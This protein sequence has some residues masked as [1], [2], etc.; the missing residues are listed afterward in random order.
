[1]RIDTF[2]GLNNKD[3]PY[4]VGLSGLVAAD[5]V[6]ISAKNK[7]SRRAG[8]EKVY[9]GQIEA[10]WGD[11][12]T[13]L[14]I[15]DGTLKSLR[16]DNTAETVASL[17]ANARHLHACRAYDNRL[18]WTTPTDAGVIRDGQNRPFGVLKP[19][20]VAAVEGIG[21][22]PAAAYMVGLTYV[23]SFL[24]EGPL[25][26]TSVKAFGSVEVTIPHGVLEL[27]AA[28]IEH[29]RLYLSSPDGEVMYLANE[30]D[31][32]DSNTISYDGD[33]TDLGVPADAANLD[34]LPTG[35]F[36]A[37]YAGRLWSGFGYDG[38]GF[39]AYTSPYAELTNAL[40]DFF[41][42]PE[43]VTGLGG[44]D[45]GRF[46]GLY[47]GTERAVYFLSGSDPGRMESR[48][49][50]DHGV[51]RGTMKKVD[52]RVV[53]KGVD[54]EVLLWTSERGICVG[55]P[56]GEATILTKDRV[57]SLTGSAGTAILRRADGQN[58]LITILRS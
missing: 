57:E 11:H 29:V 27:L 16:S 32:G 42:F 50:M 43:P 28:D 31:V 23:N 38:Q 21:A 33:C 53:G 26:Y 37:A 22:L 14:F 44:L 49:V 19:T 15:E 47:V 48:K 8:Y 52:G 45:A 34:N 58:H 40:T 20:R 30:I 36:L 35:G 25:A 39:V 18:Y 7:P 1:M 41:A 56:E 55:A 51:I 10:A 24:T 46:P 5:N 12:D 9:S 54:A 6:D 13:L 2:P 17:T 3:D 4:E